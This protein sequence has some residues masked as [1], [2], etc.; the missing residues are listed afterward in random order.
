MTREIETS[1]QEAPYWERDF[2][3]EAMKEESQTIARY[4]IDL[5]T[6]E[7]IDLTKQNDFE[8]TDRYVAKLLSKIRPDDVELEIPQATIKEGVLTPEVLYK[9]G[10]LASAKAQ[11]LEEVATDKSL[12]SALKSFGSKMVEGFSDLIS[13][14]FDPKRRAFI[15]TAPAVLAL[16]ITAACAPNIPGVVPPVIDVG[17]GS[18]A[19]ATETASRPVVTE[20]A[21]ATKEA[22]VGPV[23]LSEKDLKAGK[24]G[25]YTFTENSAGYFEI[26]D[27]QG[28]LIPDVKFFTD[29]TSELTYKNKKLT[30]AFQSITQEGGKMILGLWDYKD[31]EWNMESYKAPKSE[32]DTQ[33]WRALVIVRGHVKEKDMVDTVFQARDLIMTKSE[34]Y[35][36]ASEFKNISIEVNFKTITNFDVRPKEW[37]FQNWTRAYPGSYKF[38]PVETSNEVSFQDLTKNSKARPMQ[39]A[40]DAGWFGVDV[41]GQN[42]D[43]IHAVFV[44]IVTMGSDRS[45]GKQGGLMSKDRI[46]HVA[47]IFTKDGRGGFF[48]WLNTK[49]IEGYRRVVFDQALAEFMVYENQE[50]FSKI[51]FPELDEHFVLT[52]PPKVLENAFFT[53]LVS[54]DFW[55]E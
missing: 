7:N 53:I 1:G 33:N 12:K 40:L 46:N 11:A 55:K 5:E 13:K 29:G 18:A 32:T 31:G 28:N 52:A 54:S 39:I 22:P 2:L 48:F 27:A 20:T 4:R 47:H 16:G 6:L 15:R 35:D 36:P 14:D 26:K 8:V 43:Q 3:G 30:V 50:T 23:T 24:W 41:I 21:T 51:K 45:I 44:P 37:W 42:K 19:T 38:K 10:R 49:P 34:I 9:I 25:S 17:G